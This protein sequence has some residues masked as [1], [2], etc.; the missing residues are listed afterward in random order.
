MQGY[1]HV[2]TGNGKGK[3]TA[4]LGMIVRAVGAGFR[5]YLG[6][7]LKKGETSEI[8]CLRKRFPDVTLEQY[9][10]GRLIKDKP[11]QDDIRLASQGLT[12]LRSAML[13]GAY[14]MVIADEANGCVKAGL[15]DVE[16]LLQLVREKPRH[17]ELVFTG[18]SAHKR[19]I[20]AADLVTDMREVKHYFSRKVKA[21]RG[22]ER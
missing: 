19:L 13:S 1:V 18:R 7:F 21:R 6:Q 14:N 5:V 8:K 11:L 2:Y 10:S 3:T 9:G 16:D 15:A 22:I 17:V 20:E 4:V 12:R